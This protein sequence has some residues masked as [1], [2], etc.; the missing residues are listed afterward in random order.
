MQVISK[1]DKGAGHLVTF[2]Q[3][4]FIALVCFVGYYKCRPW[5]YDMTVTPSQ[6]L[7]L[8]AM[9]F[10]LSVLN[11]KA[12]DYHIAMPLH[13]TFRSSTLVTSLLVRE[14]VVV[15]ATPV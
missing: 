8:A 12:I 10:L 14:H 5:A 2:C 11:N 3:F 6:Y 9:F 13:I 4:A 15:C 7:V 1:F